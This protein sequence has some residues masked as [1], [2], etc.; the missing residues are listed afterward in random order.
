MGR[1][2][3][4]AEAARLTLWHG[5]FQSSLQEPLPVLLVTNEPKSSKRDAV[6][7]LSEPDISLV[8]SE[9]SRT[10]FLMVSNDDISACSPWLLWAAQALVEK[11]FICVGHIW[12]RIIINLQLIQGIAQPGSFPV[13]VAFGITPFHHQL[14]L[15]I[16]PSIQVDR[17]DL[18]YVCTIDHRC[19]TPYT[20]KTSKF[21]DAHLGERQFTICTGLI[22]RF[23]LESWRGSAVALGMSFGRRQRVVSCWSSWMKWIV[24]QRCCLD[25]DIWT[26]QPLMFGDKAPP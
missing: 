25:F 7:E 4:R 16:R 14:H 3:D 8:A 5:R 15:F 18:G 20:N 19:R 13:H 6:C 12:C 26:A 11:E 9:V 17:F 1:K 2:G 22:S 23:L 10:L 21:H 24:I